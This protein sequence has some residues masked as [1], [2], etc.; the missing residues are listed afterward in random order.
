MRNASGLSDGVLSCRLG[1]AGPGL[2]AGEPGQHIFVLRVDRNSKASKEVG[3]GHESNVSKAKGP[4]QVLLAFGGA[5]EI[6]EKPA[7]TTA[8]YSTAPV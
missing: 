1:K 4:G 8:L 2:E 6:C 3:V 7:T 5:F